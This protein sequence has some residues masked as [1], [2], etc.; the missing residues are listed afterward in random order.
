M[1]RFQPLKLTR[2]LVH[3]HPLMIHW[4]RRF[5]RS[6]NS[7]F[8]S[9][10]SPSM[11]YWLGFLFADGCVSQYRARMMV[12]MGL[13]CSDLDHVL[14]F[15]SAIKST[16]A[17]QLVLNGGF[18]K[19]CRA[20][21]SICSNQMSHDLISLGCVPRKSLILEWVH[22]MPPS[23]TSHFVRGYF[24][25]D[26]CLHFN[27]S[28]RALELSFFGTLSFVSKMQK[29]IETRV[30]SNHKAN[31]CL[32]P[33]LTIFRLLYGGIESP[34]AILDWM[35]RDSCEDTRLPRKYALYSMMQ[36]FGSISLGD[37]AMRY[38]SFIQSDE[39]K[40]LIVCPHTDN[41]PRFHIRTKTRELA[42]R[43]S[44]IDK[45]TNEI[46]RIWDDT[47]AVNNELGYDP[48]YIRRVCRGEY[49]GAYGFKWEFFE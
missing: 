41:C 19:H 13:K 18:S 15:Q 16:F 42:S 43:I 39:W 22:G 32:S 1:L 30:L 44:Q 6:V 47:A 23:M 37:R 24:D 11:A 34:L 4:P 12:Q 49:R 9:E 45:T 29:V 3:Q 20:H 2:G 27:K 21:T 33:H 10:W 46:I 35:Y 25:G 38:D 40:Q 26:G 7:S 28:K 17:V 14:K 5:I 31:G 36:N 8:F 48:S